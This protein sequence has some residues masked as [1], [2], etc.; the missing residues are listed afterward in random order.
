MKKIA[1]IICLIIMLLGCSKSDDKTDNRTIDDKMY[2]GKTVGSTETFAAKNEKNFYKYNKNIY[3]KEAANLIDNYFGVGKPIVEVN[4]FHSTAKVI[5]KFEDNLEDII[6]GKANL[7]RMQMEL[8]TLTQ[9][10]GFTDLADYVENFIVLAEAH[11]TYQKVRTL[12]SLVVTSANP[13]RVELY[14]EKV[15]DKFDKQRLTRSDLKFIHKNKE[16]FD[17]VMDVMDKLAKSL[18]DKD[19]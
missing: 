3:P 16:K 15:K 6:S 10:A 12:D 5:D 19:L 17:H 18:M 13:R 1:I 9:K 11:G 14:K 2:Q 7:E 8:N 4:R